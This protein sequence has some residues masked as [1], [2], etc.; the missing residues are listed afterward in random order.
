MISITVKSAVRQVALGR[1]FSW[2]THVGSSR[3]SIRSFIARR[4]LYDVCFGIIVFY[5]CLELQLDGITRLY[6]MWHAKNTFPWF[7]DVIPFMFLCPS[8]YVICIKLYIVNLIFVLIRGQIKR[9]V[10]KEL[11]TSITKTCLFKYTEFP[12]EKK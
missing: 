4:A 3:H 9:N 7:S 1:C 11:S 5:F 2:P 10:R 6:Q 8:I 12:T